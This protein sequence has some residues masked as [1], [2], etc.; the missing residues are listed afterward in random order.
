VDKEAAAFSSAIEVKDRGCSFDE[1]TGVTG[2]FAK[3][4]SRRFETISRAGKETVSRSP[5]AR[6]DINLRWN[7]F[8]A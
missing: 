5:G 3:T 1:K 2:Q 6:G 8:A 7:T 4:N